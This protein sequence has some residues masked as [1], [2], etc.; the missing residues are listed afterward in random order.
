VP[1]QDPTN[2][3][4]NYVGVLKDILKFD[5]A[6]MHTPNIIFMCESMKREDNGRNPTYVR[7]D[8]GFFTLNFLHK[9]PFMFDPFIFPS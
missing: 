5:Y 1:I 8:V 9:L 2:V 7:D 6:P 4:V 3:Y